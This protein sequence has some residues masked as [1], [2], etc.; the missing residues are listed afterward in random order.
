MLDLTKGEEALPQAPDVTEAA[1]AAASEILRLGTAIEHTQVAT[2]KDS[3]PEEWTGAAADAASTEIKILGQKTFDLSQAFTLSSPALTTWAERVADTRR[4]ITSYQTQ[5]DATIST[6]NT[7][8]ANAKNQYPVGDPNRQI[9]F[10]I[11][12]TAAEDAQ[13]AIRKDYKN[14]LEV[15]D[16]DAQTA[17][18]QI[19]SERQKIVPDEAIKKD[20]NAVAAMIFPADEMPIAN[21]AAQWAEAQRN[22]E[23][24]ANAI[25]NPPKT[26]E[27]IDAFNK[28][29]GDAL[30]NP[31]MAAAVSQYLTPDDIYAASFLAS[32]AVIPGQNAEESGY[33]SPSYLFN[34]NLGKLL[35]MAT[36][37]S[38]L[39]EEAVGTQRCF[40]VVSAALVGKNGATISDIVH[41]KL[42]ELQSTGR[43]Y[44][45]V[46][47]YPK[48]DP[49]YSLQG[50]EVAGQLMGYAARE[51]PSLA[52]GK[53]FYGYTTASGNSLFTDIVNWDHETN[54]GERIAM[55]YAGRMSPTCLI[56]YDVTKKD[57][58]GY[59]DPLQSILMLSDTPDA[60][61]SDD[62]VL[63][64]VEEER[65]A[66]LRGALGAS[67][68][69]GVL[70]VEDD[71]GNVT[72][73]TPTSLVRYL[74]GWRGMGVNSGA[75]FADGGEAL[76][77]VINDVSKRSSR[78]LDPSVDGQDAYDAWSIDDAN[79][80]KIAQDFLL[81][82]Q[83]GLDHSS[84]VMFDGEDVFGNNNARLR[85]WIGSVVAPRVGDLA[86]LLEETAG[87]GGSA[88]TNDPTGY[89]TMSISN[90]DL[91]HMFSKTGLFTDLAHDKPALIPGT[92]TYE[93]GRPPALAQI[94][95][96]AWTAYEIE[97][98]KAV[99]APYDP[100]GWADNVAAQT[101]GWQG[102]ITGLDQVPVNAGLASD[103]ALVVRNKTDRA[104]ISYAVGQI[105]VSKLPMGPL[106]RFGVDS[107]KD[108]YLEKYYPTDLT[109]DAVSRRIDQERTT[110]TSMMDA[111]N[112]AFLEREDGF[113]G[114]SGLTKEELDR[115]FLSHEGAKNGLDSRGESVP[116][117][118]Q[119]R[120]D[121]D[122]NGVH[123]R[124]AYIEYL[125]GHH[126][127]GDTKFSG[128]RTA[129]GKLHTAV[130]DSQLKVD[131]FFGITNDGS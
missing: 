29:W 117:F 46:P 34:Q 12:K 102:L 106:A 127:A 72:G 25:K 50:Y 27:E 52:L 95:S 113:V 105:P 47:G 70:P 20:R 35:V 5:W 83:D 85:S 57:N 96:E 21:G 129:L 23:R 39:S 54:N 108:S 112:R 11:A 73:H 42:Q 40:D 62:V 120:E 44:Y 84:E 92:D 86:L 61:K 111:V 43:E 131:K 107:V 16:G 55:P 94:D 45:T 53:E 88:N 109:D 8:I 71:K 119:L 124:S 115:D 32:K 91:Q 80:A 76:G 82:Y 110:T 118:D 6:Y 79:R 125:G 14:C 51:N 126:Q 56:P 38:N 48:G 93:G 24:L 68:D 49:G 69:F 97:L 10:G 18:D 64:Q 123:Q 87:Y 17:A 65:L 30:G 116:D 2:N 130:E 26:R 67:T 9:Q 101:A 13:A 121:E 3:F 33:N 63:N 81:G 60:L 36:G 22:A 103:D 114:D 89:S 100:N 59:L 99:N 31:F 122:P 15:L 98:R 78:P 75:L 7:A 1:N 37:G 58:L 77:D 104:L 66:S 90:K 41:T 74:S 4:T 19:N 28:E 128:D